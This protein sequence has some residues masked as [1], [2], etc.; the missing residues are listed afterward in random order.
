MCRRQLAARFHLDERG[1][2]LGSEGAKAVRQV[3]VQM[4]DDSCAVATSL[5]SGQRKRCVSTTD[6][7]RRLRRIDLRGLG[8]RCALRAWHFRHCGIDSRNL[9]VGWNQRREVRFREIA[10]IL[11]V[12]FRTTRFGPP[13]FFVPVAG[14][15]D[16]AF[17]RVVEI[18]VTPCLVG[19]GST[20]AVDRVDVL[21][22]GTRA[23]F[24]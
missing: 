10:I 12:L 20:E 17:A 9:F 6:D 15:L 1:K 3:V 4:H 8:Q 21:R 23:Q 5:D 13:S 18:D 7:K 19:D 24:V 2:G 11:F 22:L 16:G 14:L